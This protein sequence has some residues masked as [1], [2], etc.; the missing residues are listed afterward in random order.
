[1]LKL[2]ICFLTEA[3]LFLAWSHCLL[4]FTPAAF[5]V[6][7]WWLE[8]TLSGSL[9]PT[10]STG[11]ALVVQTFVCPGDWLPTILSQ[12]I[13]VWFLEAGYLG[14]RDGQLGSGAGPVCTLSG[15]GSVT[16]WIGSVF[17]LC[18]SA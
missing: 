15:L 8:E 16:P 17:L 1:M 4:P 12:Q 10:C 18:V 11:S 3:E 13:R 9:G 7:R 5:H 2:K 14:K 6:L